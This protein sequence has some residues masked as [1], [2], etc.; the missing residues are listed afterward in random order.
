MVENK[1]K[2]YRAPQGNQEM[3]AGNNSRTSFTSDKPTSETGPG[4]ENHISPIK[5]RPRLDPT[6]ENT[7][8]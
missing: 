3:E 4:I 7:F 5:P 8:S 6:H 2:K 1:K